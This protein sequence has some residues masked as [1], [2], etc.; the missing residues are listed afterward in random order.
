MSITGSTKIPFSTYKG[1]RLRDLPDGFLS[2][3]TKKL[4]ESDFYDWAKAAQQELDRRQEENRET[5][6]LEQEADELL[7]GAGFNPHKM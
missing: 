1:T 3:M 2:W 4:G 5:K 7:R 6:G